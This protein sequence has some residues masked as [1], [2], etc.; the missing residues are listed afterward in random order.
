MLSTNQKKLFQV[1]SVNPHIGKTLDLQSVPLSSI[2]TPKHIIVSETNGMI[3]WYRIDQPF[4]NLKPEEK[5]I[6]INDDIDK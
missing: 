5:S 3:N 6:T 2:M 4:E 1:T